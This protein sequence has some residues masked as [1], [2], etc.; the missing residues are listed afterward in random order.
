MEAGVTTRRTSKRKLTSLVADTIEVK[1]KTAS[2]AT[3]HARRSKNEAT[4][5]DQTLSPQRISP[6]VAN[7][8]WARKGKEPAGPSGSESGDEIIEEWPFEDDM[9]DSDF[10]A[11]D[12]FSDEDAR[13]VISLSSEMSAPDQDRTELLDRPWKKFDEN[14]RRN[15]EVMF[16]NITSHPMHG[17]WDFTEEYQREKDIEM[18][19]YMEDHPLDT[20]VISQ[21]NARAAYFQL[22]E[23]TR[24]RMMGTRIY[25]HDRVAQPP[26]HPQHQNMPRQQ[27][28]PPRTMTS[29]PV[30]AQGQRE[31]A[32]QMHSQVPVLGQ[33][34]RMPPHM[35]PPQAPP[36]ILRS[37]PY[38][39]PMHQG[40]PPP[41]VGRP[42]GPP[43][44]YGMTAPGFASTGLSTYGPFPGEQ[45]PRPRQGRGKKETPI[46][47][48]PPPPPPTPPYEVRTKPSETRKGPIKT[49]RKPARRQAEAEEFPWTRQLNFREEKAK[50]S[51]DDS[52]YDPM[53]LREMQATRERNA[54]II[55]QI[56]SRLQETQRIARAAKKTRE[57]KQGQGTNSS[58]ADVMKK[59]RKKRSG[60]NKG[61]A[62]GDPYHSGAYTFASAEDEMKA[63]EMGLESA[64]EALEAGACGKLE[65]DKMAQL[66]ILWNPG[67]KGMTENLEQAK[68]S[69]RDNV[70]THKQLEKRA[71]LTKRAAE[72]IVDFCPDMLWRGM[73]LRITSEGGYGNK[74][75][76]DRFCLNGCYCDKA[77]ITKRIS[78]ALGQ[79]QVQPKSKGYQDGELEWYEGNVKDF[80]HYIEY[81]GMRTSHRNMLKIQLA[82]D[83]RRAKYERSVVQGHQG[84]ENGGEAG[85]CSSDVEWV[86]KRGKLHGDD[87]TSEGNA[88]NEGEESESEEARDDGE[89]EDGNESGEE[90]EDSNAVSLQDSDILDRMDED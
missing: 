67:K 9:H 48:T 89:L 40:Q 27:Q 38:A 78:A 51:W 42:V 29:G 12:V 16:C 90:S 43:M 34:H 72:C 86:S 65:A 63:K 76:R 60:Q 28:V 62:G 66:M 50:A 15:Y 10:E 59:E 22:H 4:M 49:A 85:D 30:P 47:S 57:K 74:D 36:G 79:K 68:F 77:T 52:I 64:D 46:A 45:I 87:A 11:E 83:K 41:G 58:E 23:R 3:S 75:V 14:S 19:R 33:P 25:G 21:D 39:Q 20:W 54:P 32:P 6:P 82:G 80:T 17:S 37:Q 8:H 35:G 5:S 1:Q 56:D 71:I 18:L 53:I 13:S 55:D 26:T 24:W 2:T 69:V 81:F 70:L 84:Q 7:R 73:L 44:T 88:G 61:E 31:G